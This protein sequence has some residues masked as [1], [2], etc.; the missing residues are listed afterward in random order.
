MGYDLTFEERTSEPINA[1]FFDRAHNTFQGVSSNHG[2]D[3][4]IAW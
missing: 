1:I 4:G 3:Y 2:E